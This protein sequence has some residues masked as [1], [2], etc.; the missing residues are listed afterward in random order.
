[1]IGRPKSERY[2]PGDIV[3][4]KSYGDFEVVE[5]Q[6]ATKIICK[7]LTTGYITTKQ[8]R[9]LDD[10][11]IKDPFYPSVLGVGFFGDGKLT[12]KSHPLAYQKWRNMLVRCYD[13]SYQEK[14]PSYKGCSVRADWHDFQN[15]AQWFED[16]YP[17]NGDRYELD[18]DIK[19]KGNRVYGPDT[20]MFVTKQENVEGSCCY[21][22]KFISPNGEIVEVFNVSEFCRKNNLSQS[23][24]SAVYRGER[25]QHKGW[26]KYDS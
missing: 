23:H 19:I 1:M 18:K 25:K 14:N 6:S 11:A 26:V 17:K 10:G 9:H 7:S 15:F 16:N 8:A 3:T 21:N 24:M 20:C 22:K 4:S 13:D 2:Q 12:S 5:V